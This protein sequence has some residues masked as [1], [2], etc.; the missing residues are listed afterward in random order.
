MK[1][2]NGFHLIELMIVIAIMSIGILYMSQQYTHYLAKSYRLTAVQTLSK[3]ANAMEEY[4]AE[5]DTY[6]T[7][8]LNLL[9]F[10]EWI[11]NHRYQLIIQSATD[12][13]FMLEAKPSSEQMENDHCGSLLLNEKNEKNMTINEC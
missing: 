13:T 2:N 7:A 3:L 12:N 9:K 5:H 11:A 8:T 1:K 10:D 6:Q 4:H